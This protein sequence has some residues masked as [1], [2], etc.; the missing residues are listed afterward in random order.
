MY[1]RHRVPCN[2]VME[3]HMNQL[4][5]L[6]SFSQNAATLTNLTLTSDELKATLRAEI[7]AVREA[8]APVTVVD[9]MQVVQESVLQTCRRLEAS[10]EAK[11]ETSKLAQM[12]LLA[13]RLEQYAEFKKNTL[14][15][16]QELK[17]S[18]FLL[19]QTSSAHEESLIKV[20]SKISSQ[21]VELSK[22][23]PRTELRQLA[24]ELE[25]QITAMASLSSK[26]D[27][28]KVQTNLCSFTM[29]D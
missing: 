28:D 23:S 5:Y 16:I 27:F 10:L 15:Q 17:T 29:Y 13:S 11:V 24:K 3:D 20:K 25:K 12:D 8:S 6:T 9:A 1:E 18:S 21:S 14:E 22:M 26:E 2:E 19:Q 4:N 7:S